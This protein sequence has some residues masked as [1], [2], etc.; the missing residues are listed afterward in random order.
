MKKRKLILIVFTLITMNA[1]ALTPDEY[2]YKLQHY[3][4]NKDRSIMS[5]TIEIYT[6][7]EKV[8]VSFDSMIFMFF[9]GIKAYEPDLYNDFAR[10]VEESSSSRL[11]RVIE[12]IEGYDLEGYIR[13]PK[14]GP[15]YVDNLLLLYYASGDQRFIEIMYELIQANFNEQLDRDRYLTGRSAIIAVQRLMAECPAVK[16]SFLENTVMDASVMEY[17]ANT[18]SEAVRSEGMAFIK[19]QKEKGLWK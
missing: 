1:S 8:P 9:N 7:G 19:I 12:T 3:F 17:I 14:S 10:Q 13:N 16:E 11:M 18:T 5:D 6:S 15:V 4:V 2:W